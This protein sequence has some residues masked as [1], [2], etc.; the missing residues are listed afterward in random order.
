MSR[1]SVWT[2]IL[3]VHIFVRT[4]VH[5]IRLLD[6][7][8]ILSLL[9]IASM[10]SLSHQISLKFM[11]LS[12]SETRKTVIILF[13]TS[14]CKWIFNE[15]AALAYIY[16]IFYLSWMFLD[17]NY[18]AIFSFRFDSCYCDCQRISIAFWRR[19]L[20]FS[21]NHPMNVEKI[22]YRCDFVYYKSIEDM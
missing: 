16:P 2:P 15:V 22:H 13:W 17:I 9:P 7:L 10:L 12:F 8:A 3:D 6:V 4:N 19:L 5:T 18:I 21:I 1:G 11:A 20:Y 14:V